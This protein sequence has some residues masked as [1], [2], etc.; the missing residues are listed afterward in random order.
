[1]NR[2]IISGRRLT[3]TVHSRDNFT[4]DEVQK[5]TTAAQLLEKIV[6]SKEFQVRMMAMRLTSTNGLSNYDVWSK[7]L[8]GSEILSPEEDGDIDV[9]VEVF[10]SP[11]SK[12]IGYT[13]ENTIKTWI[14]RKFFDRMSPADIAGNMFHEWLHKVGFDHVSEKESTSVPY[15]LGNLVVEMANEMTKGELSL[16]PLDWDPDTHY[17]KLGETRGGV[18]FSDKM[19]CKRSWRYLW[20]KR[21][22][23]FE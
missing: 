7:I 22:C 15:A 19:F 6:N 21:V 3:V 17:V 20:L 18:V 10:S 1:M 4:Q 12:V 16:T 13:K 2:L 8:T 9:H 14:N 5:H 11:F 23:Y